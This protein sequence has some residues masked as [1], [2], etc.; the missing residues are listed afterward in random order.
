[1]DQ[2]TGLNKKKCE[3]LYGQILSE[4]AL[5]D[6]TQASHNEVPLSCPITDINVAD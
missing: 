6:V 3:V 5:S 4:N 2:K 1:M